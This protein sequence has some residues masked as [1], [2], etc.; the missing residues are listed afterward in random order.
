[1][2]DR[3]ESLSVRP[4]RGLR[5][6]QSLHPAFAV[7][8]PPYDVI[9]LADRMR[10][11]ARSSRNVVRLILPDVGRAENARRLLDEWRADG[12]LVME[13]EPCLYRTEERFT[14]PDGIERV[15]YGMIALVGLPEGD[16]VIL[17]H[18]RTM[19]DVVQDRLRLLEAT[20]AQPSPILV[21]YDDPDGDIDAALRAG[22]EPTAAI[23]LTDDHGTHLRLWRIADP[24]IQQRIEEMLAARRLLIADGHHRYATA[25]AYR[26][27]N[28]DDPSAN[29]MMMY[30]TNGASPGLVV[31]PIHR[32]V[33][34]VPAALA[35]SLPERL[36][37]A[38]FHIDA[39]GDG[40]VA[41][42]EAMA[43][44]PHTQ[45]AIGLVRHD[46]PPLLLTADPQ[47]E[48][49]PLDRID[50]VMLQE[51]I[52]GPLLDL[53]PEIVAR[54]ERI[55]YTPHAD[56]AAAMVAEDSTVGFILRAPSVRDIEAV[57]L[58]GAVMPQKSTYFYPKTLDGLVIRTL[59]EASLDLG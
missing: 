33:D 3:D 44:I 22:A 29:A 53:P 45:P 41:L 5:Y 55:R 24:A 14:G 11:I 46:L 13:D 35:I 37:A 36:A 59:D 58:A 39:P 6:D 20:Q 30:L 40:V 43:A 54:T 4:F 9:K 23:D 34:G 18:E 28:P 56:E 8:A 15:R 31:F 7:V 26:D 47:S 21:T 50:A 42:E 49:S 52:L 17:P 48:G 38:G 12:T 32:V 1:M 2:A 27:R 16:G 51:R 19:P 57:A 10:L 25:L